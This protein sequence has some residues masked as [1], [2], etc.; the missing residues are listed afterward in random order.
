MRAALADAGLDAADVVH[1]NAH[2]TSTLVGDAAEARAIIDVFG[3]RAVPVTANKAVT[4]HMMAASGAAE[5]IV[6]LLTLADRQAPPTANTTMLDESLEIDLVTGAPL[7][8]PAGPVLSNSFGFGG[9]NAALLISP[10]LG[11]SEHT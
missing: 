10:S 11:T 6:C 8:I 4:G 1:V 9:H 5:A 2:A 3:A 7:P